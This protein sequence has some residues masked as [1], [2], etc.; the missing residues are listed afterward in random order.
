LEI[1]WEGGII[2]GLSMK[3]CSNAQAQSE[4]EIWQKEARKAELTAPATGA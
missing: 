1:W 4:E 3:G 2:S